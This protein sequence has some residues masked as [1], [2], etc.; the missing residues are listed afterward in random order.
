MVWM[1]EKP[2]ASNHP[3]LIKQTTQSGQARVREIRYRIDINTLAH[4]PVSEL[5]LNEIGVISVEAQR[6]LFFDPYAKNRATGNF[7]LIDP[8]TNETV[9]AGMILHPSEAGTRTGQ[10]S[11]SEREAARGHAALAICLPPDSLELAWA[12]ERRLFD[13]GYTVH[14]IH[15]PE[16]L[17]QAVR[18]AVD[19]GLI[20]IVASA[21]PEDLD[22]VG[23]AVPANRWVRI[24]PPTAAPD[25]A[26]RQIVLRL[27][28]TGELGRSQ[29]PLTGGAGI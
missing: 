2:L 17:R 23:L 9:G 24:V 12:L 15:R 16:N 29:G 14:L 22:A 10:V 25:A 6:S 8:L 28:S 4:Q 1:N 11:D 5:Q 13:Q 21:V 19:A 27:E 20:A 3:Y 18:T 7:I 26:A